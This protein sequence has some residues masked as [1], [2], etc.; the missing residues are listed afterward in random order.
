MMG[1]ELS[2]SFDIGVAIGDKLD[3]IHRALQREEPRPIFLAFAKSGIGPNPVS[4]GHPPAGRIW[5]ILSVML[6]GTDDHTAVTGTGAL[7]VDSD[8]ASLSIAQCVIPNMSIPSS[9]FISKGTLWAHSTGDVAVNFLGMGTTIGVV[10]KI[11]VAEWRENDI[12][13]VY[14][15]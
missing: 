4:L 3:G 8:A 14:T 1:V 12:S 10:A 9:Q 6:T 15:N 2:A 7:Y 11:T 13:Q 5:N